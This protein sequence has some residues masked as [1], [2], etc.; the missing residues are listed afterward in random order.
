MSSIGDV[1]VI[2]RSDSD[3]AIQLLGTPAKAGL[4]RCAR[5]DGPVTHG[6]MYV[7]SSRG[8]TATKQSSF[9]ERRQRLDCFAALAMTISDQLVEQIAPVRV[10]RFDKSELPFPQSGFDLLLPRDCIQHRR[11]KLIPDQHLAA[12]SFRKA[13]A[14]ARAML[15]NPLRQIRRDADV[16]RTIST[17]RHH[18]N[19]GLLHSICTL[20]AVIARSG[21]TKQ[22]S[23]QER[24]QR[25]DC[26]AALA[27]TARDSGSYARTVIA[28]IVSTKRPR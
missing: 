1:A 8:A 23:F 22:S 11:E 18:I 3:D 28:R 15:P 21:A 27:M 17:V 14:D 4:L 26:F 13:A 20:F 19:C 2:A 6:P 12:V 7:P 10:R 9:Q 5:N 16:E 24:R 25:L